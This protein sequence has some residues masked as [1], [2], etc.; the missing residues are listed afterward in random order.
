MIGLKFKLVLL[1][2]VCGAGFALFFFGKTLESK[3]ADI[4]FK[5]IKAA[6]ALGFS[7]QTYNFFGLFKSK[8][9]ILRENQELKEKLTELEAKEAVFAFNG[10]ESALT[11]RFLEARILTVPPAI[12]YDQVIVGAGLEDG[13]FGGER[14]LVGESILFGEVGDV[15]SGTSRIISVSSYGRKQNVFLE[16][17]GISAVAEGAGNNELTVS[18]PRDFQVEVGD[19]IFSLAERSYFIGAVEEIAAH[20]SSPV[21]I[22]KIRQPFNVYNL[23]SLNILK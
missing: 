2:L 5:K 6:E 15:F 7:P 3:T 19:R 20:P 1:G 23:R 13:L 17:A 10:N 16:K 4:F 14:V 8:S 11:S 18:V 9:D 21:K 12:N 22:L